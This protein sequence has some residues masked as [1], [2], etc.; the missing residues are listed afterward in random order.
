MTPSS[1]TPQAMYDELVAKI[2]EAVPEAGYCKCGGW[3][4]A[5]RGS[6]RPNL[7]D[8]LR[9][10]DDKVLVKANSGEICY[11]DYGSE[12]GDEPFISNSWFIHGKVFLPQWHLGQSLSWHRDNAPET[13]AFLHSLLYP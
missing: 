6:Q 4:C 7:E 9:A 3:L 5:E 1:K 11:L 10:L 13:I 12:E 8:V 2:V